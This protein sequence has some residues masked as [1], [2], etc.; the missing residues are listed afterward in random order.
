MDGDSPSAEP[1]EAFQRAQVNPGIDV[2]VSKT[3]TILFLAMLGLILMHALG[4]VSRYVYGDD[5]VFG[6]V[7]FFD[8]DHERNAPSWFASVLALAGAALFFL[9]WR[10]VPRA[11]KP[12]RAWLFLSLVFVFVSVDE[13]ASI[14]EELIVPVRDWL[15]LSGLFYFAWVVP[16]GLCVAILGI[17]LWPFFRRMEPE[18]RHRFAAAAVVYLSGAIGMELIGGWVFESLA[19]QRNLTYDLI[20]SVEETLEFVGLILLVRAQL[21]LLAERVPETRVYLR[22]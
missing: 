16:Y 19:E 20:T 8:L 21:L 22:A 7:P 6:L 1:T 5:Y 2:F 10:L 13:F 17:S 15:H 3:V 18:V 14:H 11:D 12:S 9:L 4:L